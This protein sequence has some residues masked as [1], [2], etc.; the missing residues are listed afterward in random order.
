V[1]L[2]F[3]TSNRH[4]ARE[5]AGILEGLAEV[6]HVSL[7]CPEIRSL[8]VAEVA[9]GKASYAYSVLNRPVITDDTGFFIRSL[10]GFPGTCAAFV[11]DTI[12]CEGVLR[13]MDGVEDRFAWFEAGI[14]YA[15]QRQVRAFVGRIDGEV[16]CPRGDRG[17]G[18]DP[19]FAVNGRTLAEMDAS[20]KNAI[21]HRSR[22]LRA[23]RDWLASGM[24]RD[25]FP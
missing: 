6:E 10:N 19:I 13:L 21:S 11:H 14:A 2:T 9:K 1:N 3:V 22:G 18:Y 24:N 8:S 5:A 17:F 7:E 12:G 16:V 20:E 15:D 23:L 4:K 25:G